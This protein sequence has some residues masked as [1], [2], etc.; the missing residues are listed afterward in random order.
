MRV[1]PDLLAGERNAH[2]WLMI[3]AGDESCSFRRLARSLFDRG[4][5]YHL[6]CDAQNPPISVA[7]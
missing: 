3:A 6:R 4:D 1:A 7:C 2:R 5:R